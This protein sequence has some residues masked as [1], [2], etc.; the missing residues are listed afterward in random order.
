MSAIFGE[1]LRFSQRDGDDLPLVVQGDEM[2]A[3][4]E[5]VDGYTVVYD[6]EVGAY[7]YAE[8]DGPHFRS[9]GRRADRATPP[10][11]LPRHLHE[12]AEV[13]NGRVADR[14]R[15]MVPPDQV[16]GSR[17]RMLTFGPSG[18]L[19]P[20]RR[21]SSGAVRGVTILIEFPDTRT[22]VARGE[23]DALLNAPG[24]TGGGN[25]CSV[26][27]YFR[28]MS[29]DRLHFTNEVV[30]PYMM[31]RPRL[32]YA[33]QDGLLVPE[34]IQL[35]VD[36]GVD[37]SRFDSLGAGIVDALCIMYAGQTEYKGDLWPHNFV[38]RHQYGGVR[39]ELYIVTSM[40]RQPSDL[41]IGTFCHEAGHLLCRFP[42]LYDYGLAEREG[43]DFK[44]AGIGS[45]CVMGAGNHLDRGR[46]PAPISMFLRHLVGW[47]GDEV[48]LTKGG[49]FEARQGAYDT[50][51][52]WPTAND[53][54]YFMVENRARAG[55][56]LYSPASGLAVYH[57]D[58]NGSNEFQAGTRLRHYQCGLLQA[59][60]HLD[61]EH[62]LNQGDGSDLYGQVDGTALSDATQPAS[63][64][65]DGAAS[66]LTISDVSEPGPVITFR[67][68]PAGTPGQAV[69][70]ES[71]PGLGITDN[72]AGGVADVITLTGQGTVRS[73][74]V[75]VDITHPYTG[76][77]RVVLLSPTGRR[78]VLHN[79][80]GGSA[81]D[82]HLSLDSTPPSALAPL[83]GQPVAGQW[84][85]RVSDHARADTGTLDRWR[86]EVV[87]GN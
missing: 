16:A 18:G 73:L 59:D 65:W 57:C 7:C 77:L 10:G 84:L 86:L 50:A 36:A 15:D 29:T 40:G 55:F 32:A 31:S 22:T 69:T 27:E 33:N 35:A 87:T 53:N 2:Y 76:D 46:T 43:D 20:G 9:S 34:A 44:S 58:I 51:L 39:T 17:E 13:R 12:G 19:L 4:Y 49:Q 61:L 63:L 6:E 45:F 24:Y 30:G 85:L 60:G 28:V 66:G 72:R 68:G 67:V 62:N 11:G 56:D 5:T 41:S 48:D 23:V 42:D 37:L 64:T 25:A 79:R 14:H 80:T 71:A 82:L 81:D 78:V 8:I 70:G 75:S 74:K 52:R 21:L 47:C 38:H 26:H 54:E 83:V 1:T 3:R